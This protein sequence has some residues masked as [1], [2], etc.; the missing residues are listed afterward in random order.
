MQRRGVAVAHRED[1]DTGSSSGNYSLVRALPESAIS[2]TKD[3][4]GSSVGSPQAK[5]R[6]GGT[7]PHPSAD[8]QIIVLLS[9]AYQSNTQL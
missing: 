3:Q 6:T 9:S 1:K 8:K 5:R 7:Q 4:V 2:L